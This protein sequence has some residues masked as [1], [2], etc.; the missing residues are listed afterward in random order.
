M[1]FWTKDA[2][3]ETGHSPPLWNYGAPGTGTGTSY[4]GGIAFAPST[5]RWW[6]REVGAYPRYP[7]AYLAPARLQAAA[8]QWGLDHVGRW[9]CVLVLG[10]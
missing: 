7:H 9:G 8:A 6:G 5:W 3:C 4:E 10:G 1:A 2:V